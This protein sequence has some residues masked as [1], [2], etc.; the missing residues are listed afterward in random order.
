LRWRRREG[1]T[2]A[3][4]WAGEDKEFEFQFVMHDISEY[5]TA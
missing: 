2:A 5:G 4:V 1:G 3:G